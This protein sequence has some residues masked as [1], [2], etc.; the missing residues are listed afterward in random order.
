MS[1]VKHM[2]L[3]AYTSDHQLFKAE[4]VDT[5]CTSKLGLTKNTRVDGIW[6]CVVDATHFPNSLVTAVSSYPTEPKRKSK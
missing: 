2:V 5:N 4:L 1:I 3:L 6:F